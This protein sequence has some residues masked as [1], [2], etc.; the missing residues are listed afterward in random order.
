LTD[1]LLRRHLLQISMASRM[2]LISGI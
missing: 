2:S 1:Q